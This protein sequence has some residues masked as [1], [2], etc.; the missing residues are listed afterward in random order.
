MLQ[1]VNTLAQAIYREGQKLVAA[2]VNPMPLKRGID[3]GVEA[4]AWPSSTSGPPR[5]P[6]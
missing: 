1:G 6:K 2:G 3:Q 4:A 5:R